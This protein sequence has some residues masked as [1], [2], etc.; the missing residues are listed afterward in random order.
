MR[1][2]HGGATLLAAD[3]ANGTVETLG[4]ETINLIKTELGGVQ[5]SYMNNS[6][7]V[8]TA[9]VMASNGVIHIIDQVIL[10]KEKPTTTIKPT[11]PTTTNTASMLQ[12]L[13]SLLMVMLTMVSSM[14]LLMY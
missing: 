4:D 6:I 2:V 11:A 12:S 5:I 1:H 14:S 3:V 10:P 9:D 13:G 7:K 8:V